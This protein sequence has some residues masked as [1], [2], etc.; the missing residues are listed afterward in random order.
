MKWDDD[1]NVNHYV[2]LILKKTPDP[3]V[4]GSK[5]LLRL[6]CDRA[7]RLTF[8]SSPFPQPLLDL[9]VHAFD[10][11]LTG[12]E[13][14]L[15]KAL[16]LKPRSGRRWPE[17][18]GDTNLEIAVEVARLYD[19]GLPI[20][21]PS[22]PP[23]EIQGDDDEKHLEEFYKRS[24]GA[25]SLVGEKYGLTESRVRDIYYSHQ[26]EALSILFEEVWEPISDWID[27]KEEDSA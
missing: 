4:E 20:M 17:S 8:P 24:L 12:K 5:K 6:F 2:N 22:R 7:K 15:E 1:D 16:G 13:K 21:D 26:I 23:T 18:K 10:G 3:D 25:C 14:D 27:K 9:I 11:Y 19:K